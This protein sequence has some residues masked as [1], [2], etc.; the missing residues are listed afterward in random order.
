LASFNLIHEPWLPVKR[1]SGR[2]ESIQPWR[3]TEDID[4]DPI[5]SFEWP[6]PDFNGA[7][8]EFLIGLL[9]TTFAPEDEAVWQEHWYKPPSSEVLEQ[10]FSKVAFAFDLDGD[11]PRFMQDFE[12]FEEYS[13]KAN[14]PIAGLLIDAP[15]KQTLKQNADL[16]IK[17]GRVLAFSRATLAIALFTL[18]TYAPSGGAGHRTSL[19][20]GGPMTTLVIA[21]HIQFGST[22]W[23]RLWP[24][25]NMT[26]S[27]LSKFDDSVFPWL[28]ATRTSSKKDKTIETTIEDV[29][30]L[31]MYWG[32]P[33][34]IR[35]LFE[36]SIDQ[37]CS[38]TAVKDRVITTG[39]QTM[40][41]GINYTDGFEHPLSPYYRTN[42]KETSWLPRHVQSNAITYRLWSGLVVPSSDSLK[43]P[44]TVVRHWCQA[45]AS[46]DTISRFVAFGY[47]MD[48]MKA[49]GWSEAEMPIWL[50]DPTT[51][52][53]MER[54][55][56][57]II[58]GA[59][60]VSQFLVKSVKTALFSNPQDARGDYH[61]I[62]ERLFRETE[63][64]FLVSLNRARELIVESN[65]EDDP[66]I[67][68]REKWL[69]Q[70]KKIANRIFDENV[71]MEGVE[72]RDM[73]RV[74]RAKRNLTF[75]LLGYGTSGKKLFAQ[76]DLPTPGSS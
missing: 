24:N 4:A 62:T 69:V 27:K 38:I 13:A 66:T 5:V 63:S 44:A 47:D 36:P 58:N 59:N 64:E 9:A 49:K 75:A 34:R 51:F 3:I 14:F 1:R 67:P 71:P 8:H 55:I 23:G 43:K 28:S 31:Q 41:Y 17:R 40:N 33:R 76:L 52:E 22:L 74:I 12:K 48:N 57:Q 11:G 29:H 60:E 45:R 42:V 16:F 65:E 56:L 68:I 72:N 7:S 21:D 19:R 61:F 46:H 15:G 26:D 50:L 70:M 53:F 30:P 6:R 2:I 25:V 37:R 10:Q 20:G 73:G 39:Y 35:I 18:S 54:F 32:M